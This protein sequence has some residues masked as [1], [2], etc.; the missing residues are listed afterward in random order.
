MTA[1]DL[2][3]ILVQGL[4]ILL[5]LVTTIDW[6]RHRDEIRR[7]IALMF[8][9]LGLVFLIQVFERIS[10]SESRLVNTVEFCSLLA[11]PYLLLRLVRYFRPVPPRVMRAALA[12]MFV[13]WTSFF[14]LTATRSVI[15][16]LVLIT[17]FAGI[18]G[19]SMVSFVRGALTTS[20]VVRQ[21]LR[22]AAIG[23]GLLGLTLVLIGVIVLIPALQDLGI[24]LA[25]AFAIAAA[26]SFYVGFAP[27]RWL[28]RTWQMVELR[29][30]LVQ[31]TN[32]PAEERLSSTDS[33]NNLCHAALRAVGGFT[34]AVVEEN[35][36]HW[37]V[38]SATDTALLSSIAADGGEV[39]TKAWQQR[40]PTV[41]RLM[42]GASAGERLLREQVGA[43][44]MLLVPIATVER[45]WGLLVVFM[46]YG[47]LFVEDDLNLLGLLAQQNTFV[48]EN[49]LLVEA[50]RRHS[51]TLEQIVVQRTALLESAPDAMVIVNQQANIVLVNAQ[52]VKLF[53]YAREELLGQAVEVLIPEPFRSRHPAQRDGYIADPHVRGM[54]VGLELYAQRKDGSQFPVE[55]SLS[56][57]ETEEGILIAS[58]VRDITERK[59]AEEIHRLNT[60]LEQRVHERTAQL[61]ASNKELEAFSYSVSH[62][63]RAPLRT[64]D[65][66]SQALLEDYAALLDDTGQNLLRRIRSAS[67]RMGQLIDDLLQLS[68]LSRAE[69]RFTQVDLSALAREIAAELKE[70][71]PGREVEF[72]VKDGLTARGD[73]RLLRVALGNLIGNAWKF[74]SKQPQSCIEVGVIEHNQ[75]QA[76]FVRDN[77]AGF[78][79]TYANKLFGA[80]QRL[81]SVSEFDGTGIGLATVHRIVQRHGGQIW[82]EAAVN[83]GATFYFTV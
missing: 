20:G 79:M 49:S 50:L 15:V 54:G 30:F 46:R 39:F 14:L 23:S 4:F 10:G 6:L 75:V 29:T 26:L 51:Q 56:P 9:S 36:N 12:G 59:R 48:F 78:D 77:G 52:A 37:T 44:T 61:E 38:R 71:N 16:L 32:K 19:Y 67:Q 55:I 62:D 41:I 17:Y 66:F 1:T 64:L 27:P 24:A 72:T 34:A 60:E 11:Q 25:V 45:V 31:T 42:P 81:H 57:I 68:R 69:M 3:T 18:N 58:A 40:A 76:Y 28:R 70:Q 8:S 33:L 82:A 47:S 13:C 83:Q 43:K 2:L 63:L 80:F 53:G 65:G 74:T 35:D 73:L 22:F 7:D 5:S 21:R